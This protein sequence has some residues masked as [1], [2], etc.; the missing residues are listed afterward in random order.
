M[1]K[2][3]WTPTLAWLAAVSLALTFAFVGPKESSFLG[4]VPTLTAKRLDQQLVVVPHGLEA[5]RTLALVAFRRSQREEIDSWVRGL[6]LNQ[7]SPIAWFKM[8][9]Y[10]DPGT[11]DARNNIETQLLERHQTA[12]A[13]SRLVPVFTDREA[14]LRA[15][16]LSDS[17]HAWVLVLNR[18]GEVLARAQGAFDDRKAQALRETLLARGD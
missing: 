2:T 11:E 13:R 10:D 15:A 17:E 4:R 16:A 9:I 18:Q 7:E 6:G 1:R 8:P 14:F 12:A 5:E 3:I